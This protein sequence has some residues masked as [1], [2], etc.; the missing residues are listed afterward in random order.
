MAPPRALPGARHRHSLDPVKP[1]PVGTRV[2]VRQDPDFP[3]GPW[4]AEPLGVVTDGP[5]EVPGRGGPMPTYWIRFDEP[6]VD[7]DGDGPYESSQVLG[8]YL[9]VAA[10]K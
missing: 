10:E 2:R 5:E 4:P 9:D 1:L 7:V 6:Q 3:P 8:K